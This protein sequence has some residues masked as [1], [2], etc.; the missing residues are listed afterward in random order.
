MKRTLKKKTLSRYAVLGKTLKMG[1]YYIDN[2]D[3]LKLQQEAVRN[4]VKEWDVKIEPLELEKVSSK[5]NSDIRIEFLIPIRAQ[6]ELM[7]ESQL[8]I[9]IIR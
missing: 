8:L 6:E 9:I 3:S 5:K 1:R 2:D 4:A 7:A